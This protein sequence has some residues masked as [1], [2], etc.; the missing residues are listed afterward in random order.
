MPQ[1]AT[2]RADGTDLTVVTSKHSHQLCRWSPDGKSLSYGRHEAGKGVA[3]W[4]GDA[5]GGNAKELMR[6]VGG[7]PEWKPK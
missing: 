1:I 7:V 3:L 5:D 6:D 4:V 2:V